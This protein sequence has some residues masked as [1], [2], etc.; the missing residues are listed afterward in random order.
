MESSGHQ[1]ISELRRKAE[2]LERREFQIWT[3]YA[4]M[5][6][7]FAAGFVALLVP[8]ILW[9]QGGLRF[10]RRYFPQLFFGFVSLGVLFHAYAINQWRLLR[11]TRAQLQRQLIRT[12]A[13]EGPS[14]LDP[15]TG[16]F[17]RRYLEHL[18]PTEASRTDRKGTSLT[19][20]VLE[21]AGL[22]PAETRFGNLTTEQVFY[23]VVQA[24]SKTVRGAETLVRYAD[25]QFVLVMP[26]TTEQQAEE[27]VRRLVAAM[28]SWNRQNPVPGLRLGLNCGFATY[29]KGLDVKA[30]LEA[31]A[32][33]IRR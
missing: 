26:E 13:A 33:R 20:L 10:D 8:D 17:N 23:S 6:A 21:I 12:E 4:M 2:A 16:L 15:M 1:L 18:I 14:L 11:R 19:F 27:P 3:M 25:I 32:E 5:G 24:L 7:T 31:A 30:V 28:D 22:Q 29:R 9:P